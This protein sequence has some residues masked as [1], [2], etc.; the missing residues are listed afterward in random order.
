VQHLQDKYPQ[1]Y[2]LPSEQEI[3]NETQRMHCRNRRTV[4]DPDAMPGKRGRKGMDNKYA[5]HLRGWV[6]GSEDIKG[7]AALQKLKEM[8]VDPR[9]GELP[10]D[11]PKDSQ[12][13]SKVGLLRAEKK[14]TTSHDPRVLQGVQHMGRDHGSHVLPPPPPTTAVSMSSQQD[15]DHGHG[16]KGPFAVAHGGH[17]MLPNLV[18]MSQGHAHFHGPGVDVGHQGH[19][20]IDGSIMPPTDISSAWL[21]SRG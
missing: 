18:P 8:F 19:Q 5:K 12:I 10:K 9:T 6:Y 11:F 16:Y 13:N 7:K 17:G 4:L 3:R 2:G 14:V 21:S 15:H 1:V 20:G